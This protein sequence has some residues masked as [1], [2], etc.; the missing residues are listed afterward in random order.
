MPT[1]FSRTSSDF[2]ELRQRGSGN[3]GVNSPEAATLIG[4]ADGKKG[5]PQAQYWRDPGKCII[6]LSTRSFQQN[7]AL[8]NTPYKVNITHIAFLPAGSFVRA[9]SNNGS[10]ERVSTFNRLENPNM[11][12]HTDT[13]WVFINFTVDLSHIIDKNA[14]I[15]E[16]ERERER[17]GF[18]LNIFQ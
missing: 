1:S 2:H 4:S 9:R 12:T 14:F 5:V 18:E 17:G 8:L 16:V 7:L 6:I 13:Y 15:Q 11:E 10:L 3:L